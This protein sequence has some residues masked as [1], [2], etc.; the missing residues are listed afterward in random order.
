[1]N[2]DILSNFYLSAV[3]PLGFSSR[4]AAICDP[5]LFDR[6][7][8]LKGG[9]PAMRSQ[10]LSDAAEYAEKGGAA[11]KRILSAFNKDRSEAVFWNRTAVIDAAA[12]S[13]IEPGLPTAFEDIVWLG[14]CYD[15][16][17][18]RQKREELIDL[19]NSESDALEQSRKLLFAADEL[20]KHNSRAALRCADIGKIERQA[21]RS[22]KKYIRPSGGAVHSFISRSQ[23]GS[24]IVSLPPDFSLTLLQ[25]SHGGCAQLFLKTLLWEAKRQKCHVIVF[26]SPLAPYQLIDLLLLP[27]PKVCFA[28]ES[29]QLSIAHP[30][31]SIINARRFTDKHRLA[32]L[33]DH[34]KFNKKAADK[35]YQRAG[36]YFD[37]ASCFRQKKE[38][39]YNCFLNDAA[40]DNLR[41][42]FFANI[43]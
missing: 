3:T 34:L 24:R 9:S 36:F 15:S 14:G 40:F 27:D 41:Q 28:V 22:A 25:D 29:P 19:D 17:G 33:S 1:M 13:P 42:A 26:Y 18:L 20:Q 21:L 23:F 30:V 39:I 10:L 2:P 43:L 37:Q 4:L 5:E 32:Q 11:V 8:L 35:L 12:P 38:K 7:I 31:S 6:I 16:L